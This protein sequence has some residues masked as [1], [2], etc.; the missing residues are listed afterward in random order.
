MIVY[1]IN[2]LEYFTHTHTYIS[3]KTITKK[4]H[5]INPPAISSGAQIIVFY[6]SDSWWNRLLVE[7]NF[8]QQL[9]TL[10]Y[11]DLLHII[12]CALSWFTALH[13]CTWWVG[14]SEGPSGERSLQL[15]FG[16]TPVYM[17][18]VWTHHRDRRKHNPICSYANMEPWKQVL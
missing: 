7:H 1:V 2:K 18:G 6:D 12:W 13:S 10:S 9:Y 14:R 17:W 5:Q 15:T 16:L 4:L 8:D 11:S 3:L